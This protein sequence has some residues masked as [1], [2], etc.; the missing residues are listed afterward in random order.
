MK[1]SIEN[2]SGTERKVDVVIPVEVVKE[3]RNEVF[4]EI[5]KNAKI[6]GFRPGKAPAGV[7]E[8]VYRKE[9]LGETATRLVTDSLEGALK[10]VSA[11]P[12]SRPQINPPDLFETD[13]DF[14]YSAVFEVLPVFD[15]AE[16]K[17]LPLKR[18]IHEVRE[19]D[20]DHTIEHLI[21]HRAEIKPYEGEKAVENGD[22]AIVDFEGTID[23]VPVKDLK[24]SGLQFLVGHDRLIPEFEENVIGMKKG[25]TKEFDVSYGED[26]QIKEAA[27]KAVRY[28]FSVKDVLK[29]TLPELDD[30]LAKEVGMEDVSALKGQVKEDL[31]R[32]SEQQSEAKVRQQ[33]VDALVDKN[34]VDAPPSLVNEEVGRLARNM[35][36][37]LRQRGLNIQTLDDASKAALA[38][39]ALRNVK[40]S[41]VLAE[42]RKKED[43]KVTDEDIDRSLSGI[44]AS[45][46][47][48]AEQVR[49]VYR[50]NDLLEGLEASLAEQKVIDFII[51][52][53]TI[54]EVPG[55]PIHVDNKGENQYTQE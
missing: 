34:T 37:S 38:E 4:G 7:V 8:S 9:I 11:H 33:V 49:E 3:K 39:R 14:H 35:V 20:V 25:E 45:Y 40:T 26:F 31:K 27:G 48:A 41:I 16:Y 13:K 52:N 5:R 29:R 51:E 15:L 53:A 43:I 22:V 1:V 36:Q 18:E 19:E 54:E 6:K 30:E 17:G 44:A 47:M 23:G 12:I 42:I 10:E 28:K 24:R 2:L 50:K 46:N 55:E 32:Q 21:E